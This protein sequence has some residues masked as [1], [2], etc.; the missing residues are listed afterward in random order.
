MTQVPAGPFQQAA[1]GG[2]EGPDPRHQSGDDPGEPHTQLLGRHA[3]LD[4]DVVL[5]WTPIGSPR[6]DELQQETFEGVHLPGP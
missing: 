4:P 6:E 2:R 3:E 1:V 5:A